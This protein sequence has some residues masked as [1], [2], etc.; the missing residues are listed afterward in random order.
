MILKGKR[1]KLVETAFVEA[2]EASHSC[3]EG[4]TQ[5]SPEVAVEAVAIEE[6]I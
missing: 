6:K 4:S 3:L 2:E 1:K 5:T